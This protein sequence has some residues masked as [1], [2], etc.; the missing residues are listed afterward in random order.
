MGSMRSSRFYF[1]V[2]EHI[3]I[4]FPKFDLCRLV[5]VVPV[6]PRARACLSVR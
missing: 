2:L 3:C 5:P 1:A 4:K 6:R